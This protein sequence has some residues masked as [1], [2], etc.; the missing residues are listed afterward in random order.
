MHH[1]NGAPAKR[2]KLSQ[3]QT[4]MRRH[5]VHRGVKL[6]IST[7]LGMGDQIGDLVRLEEQQRPVSSL[8][9]PGRG[10]L[11]AA[12]DVAQPRSIA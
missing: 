9:S 11:V 12:F 2:P 3:T 8:R 1:V 10:T 6:L 4:G 5:E 7:G